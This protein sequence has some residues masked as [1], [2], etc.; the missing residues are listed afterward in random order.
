MLE[1][2]QAEERDANKVCP[3]KVE[4]DTIRIDQSIIS[5]DTDYPVQLADST[6]YD[7][8]FTSDRAIEIYD[9]AP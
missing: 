8:V 2:V 5:Y 6:K 3:V 9:V 7:V 4:N 1:R